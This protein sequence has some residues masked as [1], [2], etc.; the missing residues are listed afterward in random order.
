MSGEKPKGKI[1]P[2]LIATIAAIICLIIGFFAGSFVTPPA[3]KTVTVERT[4]EKTVTLTAVTTPTGNSPCSKKGKLTMIFH[5]SEPDLLKYIDEW[6]SLYTKL[7]PEV[8]IE[9]IATGFAD[10]L[11]KIMSLRAAGELPD[12]IIYYCLWV[13][14]FVEGGIL[15]EAPPDIVEDVK[16][17]YYSSAIE[18]VTYKGAMYGYPTEFCPY[19]LVYNKEIFEKAGVP[20]PKTWTEL[21]EVAKKLTIWKDGTL[22]QSGYGFPMQYASGIYHAFVTNLWSN[23]GE[24]IDLKAK[25]ALFNG[26]EGLEALQLW[27]DLIYKD[28]VWAKELPAEDGIPLEKMAMTIHAAWWKFTLS[29]QM[30]AEKFSGKIRVALPPYSKKPVTLAYH[31]GM[32]VSK[33]S[34]N[35]ELAWD[36]LRFINT[37]LEHTGVSRVGAFFKDFGIIPSR[38]SDVL[39]QPAYKEEPWLDGMTALLE[40]ARVEPQFVGAEKVKMAIYEE[41]E[42]VLTTGKDPKAALDD[43]ARKVEEIL[44]SL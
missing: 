17:N 21:R 15:A 27:Y 10:L 25:K 30:G 35:P 7:N 16:K 41:L 9:Y 8:E 23:G 5:W 43:A 42:A 34:K 26:P 36:F 19:G 24:L 22:E 14:D 20:V 44:A 29:G 38:K 6:I 32:G 12:I 18:A 37:P 28:K 39:K 4:V 31:W 33:T 3:V 11:P 2:Y 13:P 40:Y 1:S